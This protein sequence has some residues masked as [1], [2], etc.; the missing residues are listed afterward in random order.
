MLKIV[1]IL[2][3]LTAFNT[4]SQNSMEQKP[5]LELAFFGSSTCEECMRIKEE[6][7][8]PLQRQSGGKLQILIKD[9]ETNSGLK[10]LLRYEKRF[11]LSSDAAQMLFFPDT[12]LTGFDDILK[13]T[14]TMVDKRLVAGVK[15][16]KT[17]PADGDSID[18]PSVLRDRAFSMKFFLGTLAI[19]LLDGVNPCAIATMIFL[20]SFL[21]TRK[22]SR[23][24][25]LLIGLTY[26]ATVFLTYLAM[27]LGLKGVLEQFRGYHLIS[28]II[29]WGAFSAA[30][31]VALLS[32]K[33]AIAFHRSKNT[34]QITLQLPKAVKLRIHKIISGNLSGRSLVI[35][36][37][38]TGFLVTLLEAICTGQM[39]IPYIVA[40]T[41]HSSLRL[42]GYLYLVFYN[43]L[44]VLPLLIVMVL[45]YYG[46][47]WNDL[48]KQTQKRMVLIKVL[49]GVVMAGLAVYLAVGSGFIG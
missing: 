43:F 46:M 4:F 44:F 38:I 8:L 24:E 20:I 31:V 34:D 26:S 13:Y 48:A 10:E 17:A 42:A 33:D 23:S 5:V 12:F 35:G 41:Q 15:A 2:I 18:L 28:T 39:Y 19:G 47:K 27:G 7:L 22:R 11:H 21:A 25:V 30:V 45:A 32:F 49:L 1:R 40:M 6:L 36:S 9:V 16:A 14:R 37:I 29:R 3:L